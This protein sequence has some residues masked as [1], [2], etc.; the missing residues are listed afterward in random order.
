M[1]EPSGAKTTAD[2]SGSP[3][4]GQ[5]TSRDTTLR[6]AASNK[7]HGRCRSLACVCYVPRVFR[8]TTP[9]FFLVAS[10]GFHPISFDR[11]SCK[12]AFHAVRTSCQVVLSP[13]PQDPPLSL[14]R[15]CTVLYHVFFFVNTP[16]LLHVFTRFHCT[17]PFYNRCHHHYYTFLGCPGPRYARVPCELRPNTSRGSFVEAISGRSPLVRTCTLTNIRLKNM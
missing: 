6:N 7:I 11:T 12:K 2:G 16:T 10:E 1:R 13:P 17:C 15:L 8:A 9:S 5:R 14:L 3:A 4:C